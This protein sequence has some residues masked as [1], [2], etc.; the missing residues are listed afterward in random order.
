VA[1]DDLA[2]RVDLLGVVHKGVAQLAQPDQTR[3]AVEESDEHTVLLKTSRERTLAKLAMCNTREENTN[4]DRRD[5][6]VR[7][8][9]GLG[10][11]ERSD[12]RQVGGD[13]RLL[14]C[15]DHLAGG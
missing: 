10:V 13:E 5:V 14:A 9:T 6:A 15:H 1:L 4:L 8:H 11:L 3:D 12:H 7:L 2:D